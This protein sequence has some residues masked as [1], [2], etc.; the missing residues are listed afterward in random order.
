MVRL[1]SSIFADVTCS[2]KVVLP[3][4]PPYF[5]LKL[6]ALRTALGSICFW[7]I[8]EDVHVVK[9]IAEG[10]HCFTCRL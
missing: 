6:S 2:V 1:T 10:F 8:S 3:C 7:K 9:K 4:V 5:V